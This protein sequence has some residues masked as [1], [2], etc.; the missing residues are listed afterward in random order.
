MLHLPQFGRN[1]D[2]SFHYSNKNCSTDCAEISRNTVVSAHFQGE[3][4]LGEIEGR[5][6]QKR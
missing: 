4:L 3:V 5:L 1:Q 2:Y 6:R